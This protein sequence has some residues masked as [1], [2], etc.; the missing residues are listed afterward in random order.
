MLQDSDRL[1]A[2][3]RQA[4]DLPDIVQSLQSS[5]SQFS[6]PIFPSG[7]SAIGSSRSG[8]E[9]KLA[10]RVS[11][12]LPVHV[13]ASRNKKAH[14]TAASGL[15]YS[16]SK[17]AA[18]DVVQVRPIRAFLPAAVRVSMLCRDL[19]AIAASWGPWPSLRSILSLST[20][21]FCNLLQL[22]LLDLTLPSEWLTLP[23]QNTTYS[24]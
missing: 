16:V 15:L 12:W 20:G 23:C 24:S 4:H 1:M 21:F 8:A 14:H 3:A 19:L 11:G 6:D 2:I 10:A 18:T 22:P 13:I 17:L 9:H 5:N 7:P